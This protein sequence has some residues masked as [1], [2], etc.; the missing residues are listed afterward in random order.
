MVKTVLRYSWIYNVQFNPKYTKED[1]KKLKEKCSGFE[2][3]YKE[4]I[5]K[6]YK[7]IEKHTGKWKRKFI[8]IYIVENHK[9]F[10][11]PLTLKYRNDKDLMFV[12]L[13]HELLHNNIKRKF[14]SSKELHNY[15][16]PILRE[17][18]IELD[19]N[20]IPAL[21]KQERLQGFFNKSS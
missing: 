4:K 6:V 21:E 13:I 12:V 14:E 8:P 9:S 20:L 19:E 17:I 10:S 16:K 2:K 1:L 7:L 3:L 5:K 11:D 18:I 15:M